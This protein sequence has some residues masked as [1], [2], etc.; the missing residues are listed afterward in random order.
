MG[1]RK[2]TREMTEGIKQF[3]KRVGIEKAVVFGSYAKGE[4]TKDSD[5]DIILVGKRFRETDFH[6]RFKGLW[7]NWTLGVPVD[8]IPYTPEEFEREKKRVT[9]VSEALREGIVI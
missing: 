3:K 6:S 7:L 2:I 8:F 9:I 1:K 4:A 5:L